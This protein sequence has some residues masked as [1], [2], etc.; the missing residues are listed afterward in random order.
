MACSASWVQCAVL[1][2]SAGFRQFVHQ[3]HDRRNGGNAR[4]GRYHRSLWQWFYAH[5]DAA[6]LIFA[7][8]ID[9]Q[10]RDRTLLAVCS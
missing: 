3:L 8:R 2:A 7:Q 6:L 1:F 10:R 9:V 4:G 5:R